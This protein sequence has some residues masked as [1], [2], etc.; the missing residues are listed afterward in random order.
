MKEAKSRWDDAPSFGSGYSSPGW[1]RAQSFTS[2]Q[3]ARSASTPARKAIIEGDGR[4][5]ATAVPKPGSDWSRGD[6]VFHQK[7][8][9]GAVRAV[10]GNKL[11]VAFEK[12]GEKKVIDSFVEKA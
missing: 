11:V 2:G 6:R 7:F 9:Y 3:P 10:E 8:G 1:K 5:I 4:L 12:A